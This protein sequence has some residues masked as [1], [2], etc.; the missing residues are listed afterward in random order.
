M[1]ALKPLF[2]VV[3][4]LVEAGSLATATPG[5]ARSLDAGAPI[6]VPADG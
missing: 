3:A 2:V 4:E 6:N 1:P 5:T